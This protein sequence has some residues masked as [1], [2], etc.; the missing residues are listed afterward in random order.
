MFKKD[1]GT[2][3][4]LYKTVLADPPWEYED[5]Q[6]GLASRGAATSA[7]SVMKL[8]DIKKLPI[9]HIADK[10]SLLLLWATSPMLLKALEVM[11]AW[12]FTYRTIAFVWVKLNP[13]AVGMYSG[14]G[15]WV[16][17]NVEFV[18]LGKRGNPERLSRD[19]KQLIFAP[20]RE[21]S[22]KPEEIFDR[23]ERL[24]SPPYI[25]L[26]ARRKRA[27]WDCWGNE[28]ESDIDLDEIA[29]LTNGL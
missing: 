27:G 15:S 25:E 13:L 2:M 22:R 29:Q 17:S 7:Y 14:L 4:K 12:G 19:V 24:S 20:R 26:F 6:S 10:D 3:W 1:I 28:V 23:V 5:K 16:N 8:E 18:L 21:H 9:K 11:H